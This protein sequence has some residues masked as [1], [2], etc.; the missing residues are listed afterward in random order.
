MKLY[1]LLIMTITCAWTTEQI[2]VSCEG[3][4]GENN[5][6]LWYLFEEQTIEYS[7]NPIGDVV[8]SIYIHEN[9]LYVIVNGSNNIQVFNI[10][11]DLIIDIE[12][13]C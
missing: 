8:Q 6:S 2:F 10:V 9:N 1:I 11:C 3:N 13:L 4:F 5:G 12:R 7:G